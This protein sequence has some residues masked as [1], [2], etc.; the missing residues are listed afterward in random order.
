MTS[1]TLC[2]IVKNEAE[3]L[4]RCLGAAAGLWDELIVVDTGS[5]D[6][7]V[8]VAE[9]YGATILHYDWQYPG[10]KGAA[11]QMGI[12]AAIGDWIVVLDADEIICDPSGLRRFLSD[13]PEPDTTAVNV[14]FVNYDPDTGAETLRW[15]QVRAFRRGLYRYIHREHEMP[16]W[17]G[18]QNAVRHEIV[19]DTVFEHRVPVGREPAKMQPMLDRLS[20][21][22]E[23]HP[24]DPVPLYFLHRQYLLAGDYPA[25][26]EW[27]QRYLACDAMIDPCECYGNLATCYTRMGEGNEAVRWLCRALAEQPQ[28]RIWWTR[29]AEMYMSAGHWQI[30]MSYLRGAGELWP[31]FAWQQEPVERGAGL[32]AMID[33]CQAALAAMH[34]TH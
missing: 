27:G 13:P 33:R 19:L 18:T 30:A 24:G 4:P 14:Q 11:R 22:V 7:T 9:S 34:H 29:L 23:E 28:R 3:C 25:C 15:Y 12:D 20:L 1:I 31:Q 5:T 10:H 6:A 21:D 8:A 16:Q 26:I 2:M 17:C 32:Q